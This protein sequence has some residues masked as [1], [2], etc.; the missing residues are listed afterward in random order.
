MTSRFLTADCKQ[1]LESGICSL[2]WHLHVLQSRTAFW[3][4]RT[5]I[6]RTASEALFLSTPQPLPLFWT[7]LNSFAPPLPGSRVSVSVCTF[8]HGKES[9]PRI[10]LAA[11]TAKW[12]GRASSSRCGCHRQTRTPSLAAVHAV[13]AMLPSPSS[14]P[15][16]G[17]SCMTVTLQRLRPFR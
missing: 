10:Y 11:R 3:I 13:C 8:V 7:Y 12:R 16:T 17:T 14:I 4:S 15:A 9:Q 5:C 6:Q 1:K 2:W